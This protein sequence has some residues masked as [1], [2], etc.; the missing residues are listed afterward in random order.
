MALDPALQRISLLVGDSAVE[1]LAR[2]RVIVFGIGGVGSWCADALV[3]SG[4]GTL[5]IVDSDVVCVTNI[6]RQ[7]Q[8]T[9]LSVGKSKTAE[10]GRHLREVRP[11]AD[12]IEM[13]AVF[14]RTTAN[15]FNLAAYDYVLDCI[16]SISCKVEL[17]MRAS[18]AGARVY[19]SLGA[20]S[21]LDPAQIVVGS[22]WD[23]Y[24][25]ALG[26]YVRKKLRQAGFADEVTCIYS[27]EGARH[28]PGEDH[29]GTDAYLC[30][31][32]ALDGE[33][34]TSKEWCAAKKQINGSAVHITGTFGFMLAGLVIQDVVK[35]AGDQS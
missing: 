33:G 9:S 2:T 19:T 26:K 29:C 7:V 6:N 32:S 35:R 14:H 5:A 31:K 18:Q 23:S 15:R 20:S 12:I 25:C 17:I 34:E 4:I 13:Q 22:L 21:K 3:R 28:F 30:P 24:N 1:L 27:P 11:T 8:A 10:L 16:D